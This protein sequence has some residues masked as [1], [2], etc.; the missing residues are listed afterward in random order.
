MIW[1][2][3]RT[4]LSQSLRTT[5]FYLIMSLHLLIG[6]MFA[7]KSSRIL[8]IVSRYAAIQTPVLVVK[9]DS[10]TRYSHDEVVTHD[11]RRA[12]CIHVRDLDDI[13]QDCLTSHPVIIVEEAQF[14]KRLVPFCEHTVDTLGKHLYIV[15]LDGDSNRRAFGEI[16]EC[17]PL[18][19]T[20]EKLTSFC[21]R[22]A[23][24]TPGLFSYRRSGITDRQIEVGGPE[25]YESLCRE[26][27]LQQFYI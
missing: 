22:C 12:K 19:D 11:N 27:Y 9:P 24:G 1:S 4:T 10:D 8:D 14:F 21:Q 15:G 2:P 16:L 20:V 7:G 18:A 13:P 3:S 5:L 6:P 17:I 23:N 26:C 25:I